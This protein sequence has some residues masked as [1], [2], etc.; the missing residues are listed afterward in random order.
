MY[1]VTFLS[2]KQLNLLLVVDI[3]DKPL[4]KKKFSRYLNKFL[5]SPSGSKYRAKFKMTG[6]L[7]CGGLAPVVE[8]R[9]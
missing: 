2:L 3:P 1:G 4:S 6:N 5:Y 7:T 8:V 9:F